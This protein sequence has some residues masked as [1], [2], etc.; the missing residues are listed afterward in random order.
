MLSVLFLSVL[1]VQ[2]RTKS[3]LFGQDS[4]RDLEIKADEDR[5]KFLFGE[6]EKFRSGEV[7]RTNLN[8]LISSTVY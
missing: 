5:I 7:E 3:I 2:G 4:V 6:S 8:I 1:L